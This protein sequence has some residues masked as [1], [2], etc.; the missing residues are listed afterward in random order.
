MMLLPSI[1]AIS[2]SYLSIVIMGKP[3][4]ERFIRERHFK[5]LSLIT[6]TSSNVANRNQRTK[7]NHSKIPKYAESLTIPP[8]L[9]D[10]AIDSFVEI[11]IRQINQQ[12]LPKGYP[13][14]TLWAYGRPKDP[15]TFRHPTGTIETVK[16]QTLHVS[17]INQLVNNPESCLNNSKSKA[18]NYLIHVLQ[19]KYGTPIIDQLLHWANPIQSLCDDGTDRA[20]C[21]GTTA[22][23]YWGP[24][25]TTVH[26]HGAHVEAKSDGF[27][28][29]W[30]LPDANNMPKGHAITGTYANNYTY[31]NN[32]PQA[33]LFFHDHTLGI[34]R[35]NVY[36]AAGG[37]W[38]VRSKNRTADLNELDCKN[39]KQAL[40]GPPPVY[41]EDP[42]GNPAVRRRIR[43]IPLF[44]QSMSFYDDGSLFYPASR[45]FFNGLGNGDVFADKSGFV[46]P[47]KPDPGADVSPIWNSEAFF[48]TWVVNGKT[49]PKFEV[50]PE[51][52][53][54]RVLNLADSTTLNLSLKVSNG[55]EELPFYII[56]ADQGYLPHVVS[57]R[58][59][60]YT[61]ILQPG[62]NGVEEPQ[63]SSAQALLIMPG[64][65]YDVII[66]FTG[67]KSKTE[68]VMI[69]TAP[70]SPFDGF[71]SYMPADP[72]TIGQVLKFVVN[73]NLKNPDGD[74]STLPT[75]LRLSPN[76]T[77]PEATLN[78][79][80]KLV[81][82]ESAFCLQFNL[83]FGLVN[84]SCNNDVQNE[85]LGPAM[86]TLG[87][88]NNQSVG[89]RWSDSGEMNPALNSTEIVV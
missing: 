25:P 28:E 29:R 47:L 18:C 8:V 33:T 59:G 70:N 79:T 17:W 31:V 75:C 34:T 24:V 37:F 81:E 41:G 62:Q 71:Q 15:S 38:L 3:S 16:D 19:D 55:D 1:L 50:A 80:L 23:A 46:V 85:E 40:P 53:R 22:T 13:R 11:A 58:T 21:A 65:R 57:V 6:A 88:G 5:N 86:V 32:G 39:R 54:F 63:D 52:Y 49:W 68:V 20:N 82:K 72:A 42:N 74:K 26:V 84:A 10:A 61:Q 48:D 87:Y 51:R 64:E 14:T 45:K 44:I 4:N 12:V 60:Y 78:R 83:S 66:D 76:L 77:L 73:I 36:A 30:V 89:N 2:Y 9:H 67:I 43:E 35:L 7:L 27:P 69:N 56:G